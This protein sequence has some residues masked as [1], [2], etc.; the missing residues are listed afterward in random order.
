MLPP[1]RQEKAEAVAVRASATPQL[2]RICRGDGAWQ[3]DAISVS[4]MNSAADAF[5]DVVSGTKNV[6]AIAT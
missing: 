3:F 4:A 5:A 1:R 6:N 2:T